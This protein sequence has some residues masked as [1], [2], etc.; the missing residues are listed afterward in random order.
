MEGYGT[1]PGAAM[2]CMTAS[3]LIAFGP[4]LGLGLFFR[5]RGG[6]WRAFLLGAA[7]FLVFALVLEQ[8]AHQLILGGPAGGV[9]TGDLGLYA[10]YGGLMAGLFEETGRFAAFQLLRRSGKGAR[11]RTP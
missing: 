4:P 11:P 10:L 3:L 7:V 2:A 9:I 6:R 1:M 5:R 8:R